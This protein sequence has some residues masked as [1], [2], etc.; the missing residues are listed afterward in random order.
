MHSHSHSKSHLKS[1]HRSLMKHKSG[2][3]SHLN[4]KVKEFCYKEKDC[5]FLNRFQGIMPLKGDDKNM[6]N[7]LNEFTYK[8]IYLY[9]KKLVF[10]HQ[11]EQQPLTDDEDFE[12]PEPIN[13]LL[14]YDLDALET[15]CSSETGIC[16]VAQ[17]QAQVIKGTGHTFVINPKVVKGFGDDD[18]QNKC[19]VVQD[20][21]ST[22]DD[23]LAYICSH[24]LPVIMYAQEKISTWANSLI[25]AATE[26][27]LSK[28][29]SSQNGFDPV[30]VIINPEGWSGTNLDKKP[31]FE[32]KFEIFISNPM[33][34]GEKN[35]SAS[36]EREKRTKPEDNRCFSL[37]VKSTS[38]LKKSHVLHPRLGKQK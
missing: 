38:L 27:M 10:F 22:P 21:I 3:K 1:H 16:T 24:E 28:L 8:W 25:P 23:E 5:V 31:N 26:G 12:E 11:E 32:H 20:D 29:K 35:R 14:D 37:T 36:L 4:P 34:L 6:T 18:I 9:K 15:P 13:F 19:L 30:N 17:F 33:Q 2:H 7:D